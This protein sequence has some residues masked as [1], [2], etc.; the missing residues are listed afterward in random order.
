MVETGEHQR[1]C[2]SRMFLQVASQNQF[3]PSLA[4]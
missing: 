4:V 1:V 3:T 2:E